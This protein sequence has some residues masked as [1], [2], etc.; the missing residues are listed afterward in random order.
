M[1]KV[2]QFPKQVILAEDP[3]KKAMAAIEKRTGVS[4]QDYLGHNGKR[5]AETQAVIDKSLRKET[6]KIRD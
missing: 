6:F 2:L 5:S 3:F 4:F 1:A